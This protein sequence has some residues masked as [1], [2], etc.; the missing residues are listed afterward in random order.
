MLF[1][2]GSA[3]VEETKAWIGD[4][5]GN[6]TQVDLAKGGIGWK[7]EDPAVRL[8][9]IASPAVADNRVITGNHD[10]QIYCFDKNNGRL[11]WKFNT[12]NRVE[13]S[14]VIAGNKVLVANMRGDLFILDTASG[15]QDWTYELGAAVIGNP[16]VA[17]RRIAVGAN[18]GVVYFFG[19]K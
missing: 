11:L 5:D 17:D 16:A 1:R 14:P 9:F 15:K 10:K 4:Y 12:G 2:S 19:N 3:A 13:A 8:P 7:W 18:D 6:F